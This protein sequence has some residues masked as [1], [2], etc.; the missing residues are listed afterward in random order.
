MGRAALVTLLLAG[1]AGSRAVPVVRVPPPTPSALTAL[2]VEGASLGLDGNQQERLELAERALARATAQ[3]RREVEEV[4]AAKGQ[5]PEPGQEPLPPTDRDAGRPIGR[6]PGEL[7]HGPGGGHHPGG[8]APSLVPGR[9]LASLL[10][11]IEDAEMRAYLE[12]E[13]WL[14]APLRERC[15]EVV[16]R[17]RERLLERHEAIRRR[18]GVGE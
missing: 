8:G 11:Q 6:R 10:R 7:P 9:H 14:P 16:S 4:L 18:L 5:R 1:C 3:A 15:R 12:V 2:S 17:Q 13:A